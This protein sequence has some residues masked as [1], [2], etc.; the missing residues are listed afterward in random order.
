MGHP[1]HSPDLALNDFR[2]FLKIE[3]ALNGQRFQD[4][5]DKK[6]GGGGDAS[7]VIYSTTGIPKMFPS[8]MAALLG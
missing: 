1:P 4:T 2:L 8:I 6:K 3:S 5:D 7:N